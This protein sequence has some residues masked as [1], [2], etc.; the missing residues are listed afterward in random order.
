MRANPHQ[1]DVADAP[2]NNG[3]ARRSR[4]RI[5]SVAIFVAAAAILITAPPARAAS[6]CAAGT[7]EVV[8]DTGAEFITTC[9]EDEVVAAAEDGEPVTLAVETCPCDFAELMAPRRLRRYDAGAGP[10][11]SEIPNGLRLVGTKTKPGGTQVTLLSGLAP[12]VTSGGK[13]C[14]ITF[15]RG[16][17]TVLDF[18]MAVTTPGMEYAC[19]A[20][21]DAYRAAVPNDEY[22]ALTCSGFE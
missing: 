4:S 20:S 15:D 11:C 14:R 18:Q 16:A 12:T 21:I 9:V 13:N 1:S 10:N 2:S 17:K 22:A 19:R 7:T 6:D 5:L 8:I 3:A